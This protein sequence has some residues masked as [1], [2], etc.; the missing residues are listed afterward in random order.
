MVAGM[1]IAWAV[2]KARKAAG[3]A[4]ET[5]D[6]AID[7]GADRL[8][9]LVL[10]RLGGPVQDD[11]AEEAASESGQVS[12]LTRQ[13]VELAV[14]AAARRDE[15]FAKTVTDLLEQLRQAERTAGTQVLAA[16][17][18]AVFTGDV[19]AT[20]YDDA[21]AIGQAGT[22]NIGRRQREEPDPR[23]PGRSGH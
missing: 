9:D 22:V 15:T 13:Q 2:R 23:Q 11:L 17:G 19:T 5:V 6:A 12:E 3:R 8:H 10:S 4:D 14:A 16:P 18:S 7:A 1:V 20:A 21:T